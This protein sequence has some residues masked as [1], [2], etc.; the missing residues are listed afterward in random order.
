MVK[1]Y[2][3]SDFLTLCCISY[4]ALSGNWKFSYPGLF[5]VYIS[6]YFTLENYWQ[7]INSEFQSRFKNYVF[8]NSPKKVLQEK[9]CTSIRLKTVRK[10][11]GSLTVKVWP[12]TP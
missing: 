1:N 11:Y 12:M 3:N 7:K 9:N 5:Y 10:S 2:D 4:A 6:H 8:N